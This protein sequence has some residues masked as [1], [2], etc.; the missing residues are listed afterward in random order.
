MVIID[1]L[2]HIYTRFFSLETP[3]EQSEIEA[4]K[5]LAKIIENN[6]YYDVTKVEIHGRSYLLD[7]KIKDKVRDHM[8]KRYDICRNLR[9]INKKNNRII[10]VPASIILEKAIMNISK[11]KL[12]FVYSVTKNQY[13]ID[14]YV[15]EQICAKIYD[16]F[17]IL[18]FIDKIKSLP[19]P[20]SKAHCEVGDSDEEDV[21]GGGGKSKKRRKSKKRKSKMRKS[22]RRKSKR[23]KTRRNKR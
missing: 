3:T 6:V 23:R 11:K 21:F 12:A 17:G 7:Q 16:E 15:L 5:L 18:K 22:K 9:I 13:D 2:P 4:E 8:L 20:P 1:L 14:Y 10:T 19:P